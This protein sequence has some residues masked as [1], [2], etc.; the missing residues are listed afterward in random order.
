ME[1]E[2]IAKIVEDISEVKL[3][4]YFSNYLASREREY[5]RIGIMERLIRLEE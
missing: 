2:A 4:D 5:E 3:G 1:R